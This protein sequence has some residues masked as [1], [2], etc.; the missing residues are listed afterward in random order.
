ME[1]G[2]R[3][4]TSFNINRHKLSAFVLQAARGTPE[5][6]EILQALQPWANMLFNTNFAVNFLLYCVSGRNFRN[7]LKKIGSRLL[8]K[9]RPNFNRS[10]DT[11]LSVLRK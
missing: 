11:S 5:G 9:K 1:W 8:N 3:L 4:Y 6:Q 7:S 2:F 10:L